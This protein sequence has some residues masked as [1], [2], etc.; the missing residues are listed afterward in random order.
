M[1]LEFERGDTVLRSREGHSRH[2]VSDLSVTHG[3][4]PLT[5]MYNGLPAAFFGII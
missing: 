4:G 5:L 2:S 3:G 1:K